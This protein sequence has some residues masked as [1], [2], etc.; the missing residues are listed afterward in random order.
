M[1]YSTV[2]PKNRSAATIIHE[3]IARAQLE[4]QPDAYTGKRKTQRIAWVVPVMLQLNPGGSGERTYFAQSIDIGP[5]GMGVRCPEPIEARS[6][7]RLF[8][9]DGDESVTG[10]VKHCSTTVGAYV[11]GI[12]F[13]P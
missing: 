6:T 7:V 8:A 4:G 11:L 2:T 10:I 1:A 5:K 13:S 12:Q 9:D 3:W